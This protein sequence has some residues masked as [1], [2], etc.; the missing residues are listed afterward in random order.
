M[1]F[2]PAPLHKSQLFVG[3]TA[4]VFE[5]C[6]KYSCLELA[7]APLSRADSFWACPYRGQFTCLIF[8]LCSTPSFGR[9][10]I[11]GLNYCLT[12]PA[13]VV[14]QKNSVIQVAWDIT[15]PRSMWNYSECDTP[16]FP[17][18]PLSYP[19]VILFPPWSQLSLLFPWPLVEMNACSCYAMLLVT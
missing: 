6:S 8:S 9:S 12:R 11:S 4:F 3:I 19:S 10:P 7:E 16:L 17:D 14:P 1:D 15:M 2:L 5:K 18:L 13:T